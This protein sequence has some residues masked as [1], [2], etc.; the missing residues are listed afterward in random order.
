M[1]MFIIGVKNTILYG[2]KNALYK[3]H[4]RNYGK[5]LSYQYIEF[6]CENNRKIYG[7]K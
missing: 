7:G 3:R 5:I 2:V 4:G 1:Q 6:N